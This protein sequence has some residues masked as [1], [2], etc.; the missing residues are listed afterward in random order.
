[1]SLIRE[2]SEK[3]ASSIYFNEEFLGSGVPFRKNGK[4]YCLTCGHVIYGHKFDRVINEHKLKVSFNGLKLSVINIT[5]GV[6]LVKNIDL[7][8]MEIEHFD[9]A[10]AQDDMFMELDFSDPIKN[11]T[12]VPEQ[13][14][15]IK[16]KSATR[17]ISVGVETFDKEETKYFYRVIVKKDTFVH[18]GKGEF[19]ASA[20]KGISGSGLFLKVAST[21]K[22]RLTGLVQKITDSTINCEVI[23][24]NINSITALLDNIDLYTEKNLDLDEDS[25]SKTIE[26]KIKFVEDETAENWLSNA[27]NET[28]KDH[29]KRKMEVLHPEVKVKKEMIKV[30]KNLLT[31]NEIIS[32]WAE[33]SRSLFNKYD[34]FNSVKSN[35]SM[36]IYHET[37]KEANKEFKRLCDVHEMELKDVLNDLSPD[38]SELRLIKN[39]DISQ[40]LSICD[41]DFE[42]E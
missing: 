30:V 14:F 16:E 33:S 10:K 6:D 13:L 7:I 32:A 1:M 19:G 37:R 39:R 20:Y 36:T 18:Y 17:V 31:G 9:G 11:P 3:L 26:K 22:I 25:L 24:C 35:E 29:I 40:W 23:L 28:S 8:L 12:Y 34:D 42:N 41:L 5:G 27:I 2:Q 21:E 4:Y 15:C 38:P